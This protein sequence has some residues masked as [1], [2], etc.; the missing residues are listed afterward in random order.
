[1]NIT[2]KLNLPAPFVKYAS[3]DSHERKP[4]QYS[5][6]ELLQ[7]IRV[8]LLS[9][10]HEDEIERDVADTIPALFGTAVHKVIEENTDPAENTFTEDQMSTTF[11]EDIVTGRIDYLDLNNATIR[12]YKTCSVSKV[13]KQDFEEWRYQLLMYAYLVWK[14]RG[15]MIRHLEIIA[16]LK[17]WSKI[18]SSTS[19]NY[20]QSGV[21]TWRYEIQDS[22]YDFIEK[23][24]ADRLAEINH[25]IE[26][27]SLPECSNEERWYTGDKWAV[28]KKAGDKRAAKVLDSEQEAHDYITSDCGGVGEI[29]FREGE[30]TRCKFYCDCCRFCKKGE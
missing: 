1:M 19:I 23:W 27:G 10:M 29:Q 30:S 22:D 7:P 21:Y 3:Q 17:D 26:N 12:D 13:M 11:G 16:L 2:N 6:T 4:H 18:K 14:T 5:V 9:R 24:M 15:E 8:I 20:P 28:F 25:H